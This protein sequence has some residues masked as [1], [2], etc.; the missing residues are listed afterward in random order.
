[1]SKKNK[2]EPIKKIVRSKLITYQWRRAEAGKSIKPEHV[3]ALE[4]SAE[5]RISYMM[6]EGNTSGELLDNIFMTDD[7]NGEDGNQDGIEYSGWW[8]VTVPATEG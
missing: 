1:M 3:G 2:P 6:K 5:D 4:E 7:D 8:K